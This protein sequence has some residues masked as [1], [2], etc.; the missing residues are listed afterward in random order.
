P[1]AADG[2]ASAA[3]AVLAFTIRPPVWRRAWFLSLAA[4]LM[5]VSGYS[6]YRY[7]VA[8]LIELERVRTRIA[9]D[10]HDDIGSGLSQVAILSEVVRQQSHDDPATSEPLARIASTSRELV[11][12]MSDIVWAID[13]RRDTPGDLAHRMRR[14]AS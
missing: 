4:T 8:R 10:L 1:L 11:D 9:G 6:L 14:F 13:P 7:R 12:S 5:I 3:P 2:T